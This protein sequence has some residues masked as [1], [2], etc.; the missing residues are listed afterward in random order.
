[1]IDD[2]H[3]HE[4]GG[5][6][7]RDLQYTKLFALLRP[8]IT[9]PQLRSFQLI[10]NDDDRILGHSSRYA[11]PIALMLAD[12]VSRGATDLQPE[13]APGTFRSYVDEPY[14]S[15][16]SVGRKEKGTKRTGILAKLG[17]ALTDAINNA[18]AA[19]KPTKPLV[20]SV[21]IGTARA[22]PLQHI[23]LPTSVLEYNECQQVI[24]S[25]FAAHYN[26]TDYNDDYKTPNTIPSPLHGILL[27][28]TL[29]TSAIGSSWYR[30]IIPSITSM[31]LACLTTPISTDAIE[32]L[33]MF[34]SLTSL[35]LCAIGPRAS[36]YEREVDEAA[37]RT[38]IIWRLPRLR[39]LTIA[40]TGNAER[41]QILFDTPQLQQFHFHSGPT[42]NASL[43]SIIASYWPVF[44]IQVV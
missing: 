10:S 2:M 14:Y 17:G 13:L 15:S 42:H 20:P 32:S 44:A 37:P 1:M 21:A 35:Y 36:A 18:T 4:I 27:H 39:D 22:P 26:H 6:H 30:Q 12:I 7:S 33:S 3:M 43:F 25:S 40:W 23:A 28:R 24:A 9:M 38:P 19:S 29:T 34:T 8:L 41:L 5:S 31:N 16:K 11:R